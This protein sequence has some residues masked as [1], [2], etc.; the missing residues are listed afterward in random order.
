MVVAAADIALGEPARRISSL[1][2]VLVGAFALDAVWNA[3]PSQRT[4]IGGALECVRKSEHL[5]ACCVTPYGWGSI[6]AT[7]KILDLLGSCCTSSMNRFPSELGNLGRFELSILALIAGRALRRRNAFAAADRAG[8]GAVAYGAFAR[9]ERRDIRT[10]A[11]NHRTLAPVSSQFA[12]R[13][14]WPGRVAVP[15]AST[16]ILVAM[17]GVF[18][19]IIAANNVYSP[20]THQ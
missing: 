4:A 6:L 5:A 3:E 7:R 20:P 2:S 18:A 17:L 10:A 11:A 13:P 15:I 16:V 14:G 9:Q 12:L 8:A 1:A 19:W